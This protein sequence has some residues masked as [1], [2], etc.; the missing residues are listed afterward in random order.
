MLEERLPREIDQ[1]RE[2]L[3]RI[4]KLLDGGQ[5]LDL[6]LIKPLVNSVNATMETW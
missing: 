3:L 5:K 1:E 2:G 6:P 4:H